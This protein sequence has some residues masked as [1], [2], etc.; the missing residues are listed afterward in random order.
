MDPLA[1]FWHLLNFLA[2]A[3]ALALVLAVAGRWLLPK[4][5]PRLAWWAHTAI[6][7]AVGA[8]VSAAGLWWYGRDGKM[9]T[10]AA[11]VLA[12]ATAQWLLGRGWRG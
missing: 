8:A 7:F 2:P 10:Y 11:L 6:L 12:M 4:Q 9:A 1:L 5:A 3:A